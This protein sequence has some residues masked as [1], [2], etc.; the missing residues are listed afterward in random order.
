MLFSDIE[1]AFDRNIFLIEINKETWKNSN[2]WTIFTYFLINIICLSLIKRLNSINLIHVANQ[3]LKI[4]Q[5][6]ATNEI[7]NFEKKW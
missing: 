6:K 1:N 2:C 5:L 4:R 3:N 7:Q